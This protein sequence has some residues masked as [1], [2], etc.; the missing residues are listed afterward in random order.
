MVR[1]L[2]IGRGVERDESG[3]TLASVDRDLD[4]RFFVIV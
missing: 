1:I 4:D 3:A 2:L